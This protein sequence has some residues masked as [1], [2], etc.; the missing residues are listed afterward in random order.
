MG[1]VTL[2]MGLVLLL[3]LPVKLELAPYAG[4]V[5][6]NAPTGFQL[7]AKLAKVGADSGDCRLYVLTLTLSAV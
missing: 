6:R 2:W 1:A 7:P 5:G 3:L 4:Y